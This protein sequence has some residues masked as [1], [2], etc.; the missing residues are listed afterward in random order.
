MFLA[1]KSLRAQIK[2]AP[3]P[4]KLVHIPREQN[5][6]ADWLTNL[7]RVVNR[8]L[9]WAE[10]GVD[11]HQGQGVPFPVSEAGARLGPD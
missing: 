5:Q 11:H 9:D 6:V 3:F 2:A 10:L 4:I 1:V 8:S 7:P